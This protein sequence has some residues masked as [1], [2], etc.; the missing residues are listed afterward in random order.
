MVT[1]STSSGVG[2]SPGAA[3]TTPQLSQPRSNTRKE[4]SAARLL[5]PRCEEGIAESGDAGCA[6]S[7]QVPC[8]SLARTV[9]RSRKNA[10]GDDD[11]GCGPGPAERPRRPD[12][13]TLLPPAA[14]AVARLRFTPK[15]TVRW[16]LR[17]RLA[18]Q[19][20]SLH[21]LTPPSARGCERGS[22]ITWPKAD[23]RLVRR[24][25]SFHRAISLGGETEDTAARFWLDRAESL[26]QAE[27]ENKTR[28]RNMRRVAKAAV[29][30]GL[31][32]GAGGETLG[33]G[34][35]ADFRSCE[36]R[37]RKL[38]VECSRLSCVLLRPLRCDA[39]G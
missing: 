10:P 32:S 25:D 8:R 26:I 4:H 28:K 17:A 18:S 31:A 21:H 29:V 9:P 22:L 27:K 14:A 16:K 15:L 20:P 6:I 3:K 30:S 2:S 33:V 24:E 1:Y 34:T 12:V 5:A 38:R 23:V 37:R 13:S 7:A 35:G 36:I 39:S 11:G 19:P